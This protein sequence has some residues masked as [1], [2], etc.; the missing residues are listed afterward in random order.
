MSQITKTYDSSKKDAPILTVSHLTKSY[1]QTQ[2]LKDINLTMP[3]GEFLVLVGPSGCGK[4]TLLSCIGGLT[5]I[6]SGTLEIADR[7]VSNMAPAKRDIAMVFQSYALFPN[8]TVA[9][10]IAYGLDVR[11]IDRETREAAVLRVADMLNMA[12]LLDRK[13]V[14]LSG[15]QRQ[16]VA[17]GRALVREPQLFLFDEPL[18]NLDAKLRFTMRTEIK[19]LHQKLGASIIYVTHDQ[20]EAMTLATSIVVM[21]G[22][23]I[24]QIGTP[25]EVYDYPANAFVADFMGAPAM[26]LIHAQ[27]T[28]HSGGLDICIAR[29]DGQ[30]DLILHDALPPATL[31]KSVNRHV[32]FGIRPEAITDRVPDGDRKELRTCL[33]NVV[34]PTGSDTYAVIKVS[35]GEVIARL[36]GQSE[37]VA[38]QSVDLAFDMSRVSY[39]DPESEVRL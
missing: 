17:M 16:R 26:N 6:T 19:R 36:H 9:D 3:K 22:G 37:V 30:P 15:G 34:E 24:Q 21:R 29:P 18:S 38:G 8:L 13:P 11:G 14:Q 5:E 7:D 23:V 27:V 25:R 20:I 28:Y 39:F 31:L 33:L 35:Q 4:S 32:L 1:D 2:I 10:N 12:H